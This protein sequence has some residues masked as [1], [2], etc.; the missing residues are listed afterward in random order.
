MTVTGGVLLAGLFAF[1]AAGVELLAR[2]RDNPLGAVWSW[3]A[4]V[5]ELVNGVA[6]VAAAGWLIQFFPTPVENAAGD[7]DPLKLAL[8]AGLGSLAVFR[9]SVMKLRISNGQDISVGPAVIVEQLLSVVDRSVDRHLAGPRAHVAAELAE[10]LVFERDNDSL[11]ALCLV[12]LQNPTPNEEQEMT[13]LS[14]TL[15]GRT[16]MPPKVKKMIMLLA[17]LGVVG[18]QVLRE[19]VASLHEPAPPPPAA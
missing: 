6:A 10:K 2:Y 13:T 5:Y 17:L 7:I 9:T 3:P 18:E 8:V 11:V 14:R 4:F 1:V 15:A 12:L 19:A 16:D